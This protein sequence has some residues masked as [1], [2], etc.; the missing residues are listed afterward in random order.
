MATETTVSFST[1]ALIE[2]VKGYPFLTDKKHPE[3]KNRQKKDAA[4]H[5][6]G[7]LFGVPGSLLEK[8]LKNLKDTYNRTKTAT[9]GKMKS[10]AAAKDVPTRQWT[11]FTSMAAIMEKNPQPKV[12]YCNLPAAASSGPSE[13]AA[14]LDPSP[15]LLP[16]SP[17]PSSSPPTPDNL[18]AVAS[19]SAS[20]MPWD[21]PQVLDNGDEQES[22]AQA[23]V[24]HLGALRSLRAAQNKDEIYYFCMRLDARLRTL[25]RDVAEDLINSI[26]NAVHDTSK[27]CRAAMRDSDQ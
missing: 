11:H 10:G 18:D 12:V 1:E 24:E 4:W 27:Q 26:E 5:Q 15:P 16:V 23:A 17:S 7:V 9:K 21:E 13:S 2:V 14:V 25:P 19:T 20:S 22:L 6:I 8:K 3:F